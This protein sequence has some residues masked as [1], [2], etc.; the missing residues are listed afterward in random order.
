MSLAVKKCASR[1]ASLQV[2]QITDTHLR[3]EAGGKLVGMDTDFSLDQVVG[4]V[5]REQACID[6]VLGTGDISDNG[7]ESAYG[8]AEAYFARLN[9]PVAW[10]AGNHDDA[11]LMERVLGKTAGWERAVESRHWLIVLLNSRI[12]GEVGGNLGEAELV[13]LEA[14]LEDAQTRGLFV[15]VCLHHQPVVIGSQWIDEQMV[16]D[17]AEFFE[18]L[19]RYDTVRGV[20]WGHVHQQVDRERNGVKLMATPSSCV[21]FAPASQEFRLDDQPPGYRWL[22]LKPDGGIDT[23]VSRVRGVSFEVDLDSDGY[24]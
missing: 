11:D 12:P 17:H 16:A 14:C 2:V 19:D 6:L 5:G 21:Q 10:L 15:L 1:G 24:L 8:R 9:A 13:W 23:G 3:E 4:L 18:V 20:L 22:E 7:S